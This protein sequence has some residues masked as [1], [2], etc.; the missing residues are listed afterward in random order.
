MP[1]PNQKTNTSEKLHTK[2]F[3]GIKTHKLVVVLL[4]L[5]MIF[6]ANFAYNYY[7]DW[8]NALIIK[9]LA[10]DFPTLVAEIESATGLN[11]EIKSDCSITQEKFSEGVKTCE[12]STGYVGLDN[13]DEVV[14][15]KVKKSKMFSKTEDLKANEGFYVFYKNKK[16]CSTY[17]ASNDRFNISCITAV[18]EANIDLAREVFLKQ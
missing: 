10:K 16:A 15:E 5:V 8:D 13:A 6:P 9:G 2:L 17:F 12:L 1:N 3:R 11:L 14:E 18:R 7:K 4:I